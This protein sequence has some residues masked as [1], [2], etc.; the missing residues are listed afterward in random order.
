MQQALLAKAAEASELTQRV[1]DAEARA[2]AAEERAR[3]GEI[4]L[5]RMRRSLGGA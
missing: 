1:R 4:L 5:Q 2:A 3:A